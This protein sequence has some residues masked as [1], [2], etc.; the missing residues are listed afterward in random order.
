M[1]GNEFLNS[2]FTKIL[3]MKPSF[4]GFFISFFLKIKI[5]N[6]T[7]RFSVSRFVSFCENQLIFIGFLIHACSQFLGSYNMTLFFSVA[8][9]VMFGFR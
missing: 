8:A 7:D 1:K 9:H 2:V 6:Q 4:L 3:K 5:L